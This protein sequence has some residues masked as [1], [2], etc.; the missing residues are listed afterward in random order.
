MYMTKSEAAKIL[1][2]TEEQVAEEAAAVRQITEGGTWGEIEMRAVR[3]EDGVARWVR[4][5]R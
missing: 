3:G 1:G 2:L 4:T 5:E